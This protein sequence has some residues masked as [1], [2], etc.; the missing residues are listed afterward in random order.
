[1]LPRLRPHAAPP[2][3]RVVCNGLAVLDAWQLRIRH[4]LAGP[5]GGHPKPWRGSLRVHRL[6][7]CDGCMAAHVKG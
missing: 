5:G 6:Q 4:L 2:E 7:H 3:P 1:M